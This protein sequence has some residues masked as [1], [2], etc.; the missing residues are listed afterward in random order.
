MRIISKIYQAR[1]L[2][3]PVVVINLLEFKQKKLLNEV[4]TLENG[5]KLCLADSFNVDVE[6]KQVSLPKDQETTQHIVMLKTNKENQ[7]TLFK[8]V[9]LVFKLAKKIK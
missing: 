4:K 8:D 9:Q 7:K 5:W 2:S 6:A 3:T 1:A